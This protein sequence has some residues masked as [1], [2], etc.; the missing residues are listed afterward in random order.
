VGTVGSAIETPTPAIRRAM[1]SSAQFVE[2]EPAMAT[3]ANP[4][5][6]KKSPVAMTGRRPMRSE[7][8]PAIGEMNIG[9]AKKGSRRTPAETGE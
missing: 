5:V 1:S 7:T 3:Q 9:V 2:S 4:A 6:C 8:A